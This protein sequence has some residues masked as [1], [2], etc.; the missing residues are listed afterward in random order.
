MAGPTLTEAQIA[1]LEAEKAK[2]E[3]VAATFLAAIPAKAARAAE[4][5]VA[6]QAFKAFFDYYNDDIIAQYDAERKELDGVYIADPITETD[7]SNPASLTAGR[8]TP[9][10]PDTDLIRVAEFDGG[11]TTTTNANEAQH[12]TDQAEIETLLTDGT[13]G[14]NPSFGASTTTDTAINPSSNSVTLSDALASFTVNVGDEFVIYGASDA[15]VVR[16][17]TTD[18]TS[19]PPDTDDITFEYI[20]PPTGTIGAGAG[21]I[22]SFTG[23]IDAERDTK[24]ASDSDLQ[25][26]M[27]TLISLLE[28]ELNSRKTRLAAQIVAIDANQDPDGVSQLGLAKTNAETSDAFITSYLLTTDIS[29]TGIGALSAER[30][31]RNGQITARIAEISASY[32]GQTENYYDRRYTVANDRGSTSRGTLRLKLNA[33]EGSGSAQSYA[34]NAQAQVDAINALLGI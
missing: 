16:V 6:D 17:L 3:N 8:T 23:F 27:D 22:A 31:T 13:P 34:D 19:G 33:E 29:D 1:Q 24:T 18:H 14:T 15:A 12:I 2:A 9:S 20:I 5:D 4:L 11:N 10:L 7:I 30:A 28:S 25:P 21:L 26:I 32:T